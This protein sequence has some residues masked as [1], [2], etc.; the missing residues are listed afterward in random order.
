MQSKLNDKDELIARCT[1]EFA[2]DL[3]ELK[4]LENFHLDYKPEKFFEWYTKDVFVYRLLNKALPIHSKRYEKSAHALSKTGTHSCLIIV[5]NDFQKMNR[6]I[7]PTVANIHLDGYNSDDEM[8]V[9]LEITT[10]PK[11]TDGVQPLSNIT[12]FSQ[13]PEEEEVLFMAGIIFS[14]TDVIIG[15]SFSA[16]K[17]ELRSEEDNDLKSLFETLLNEYRSIQIVVI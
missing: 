7:C 6:K 13:Y 16:V 9:L 12:R 14:F 11:L 1:E 17:L 10:D 4:K 15:D 5:A 3:T 8:R 2:N